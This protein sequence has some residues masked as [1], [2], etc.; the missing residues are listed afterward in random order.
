MVTWMPD[1]SMFA[2]AGLSPA[3]TGGVCFR[4]EI[5]RFWTENRAWIVKGM[6]SGAPRTD[7]RAGENE[8]AWNRALQA[9]AGRG[10]GGE[11]PPVA[12]RGAWW[13]AFHARASIALAYSR[14]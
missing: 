8:P 11:N 1:A 10:L 2:C 3:T 6:G 7:G 5:G 4:R 13:Q 14:W 9:I 12:P